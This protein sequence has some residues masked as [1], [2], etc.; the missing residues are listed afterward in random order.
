[1]SLKKGQ[2]DKAHYH[3]KHYMYIIKGGKL[4]IIG[5]TGESMEA[6]MQT[7]TGMI[8]SAGEQMVENVGEDDVELVFLEVGDQNSGTVIMREHVPCFEAE[9]NHYKVVAE[10]D[11]W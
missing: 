1:M 3:P 6:E 10:D 7:G 9:P 11:D 2:K 5:A 8:M 4:K